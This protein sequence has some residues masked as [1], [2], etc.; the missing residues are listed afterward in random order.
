MKVYEIS[1][2]IPLPW[3]NFFE[4]RSFETLQ[5]EFF[6]R[7]HSEYLHHGMVEEISSFRALKY[8]R[9]KDFSWIHPKTFPKPFLWTFIPFKGRNFRGINFRGV[10][11][12]PRKF[13]PAKIFYLL[14][15]QKLIPAKKILDIFLKNTQIERFY[16]RKL[17]PANYH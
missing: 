1:F 13:V 17:I 12:K 14:N 11:R 9:M 15:L 3:L 5:N 4:F 16:S 8:F 10:F 6:T 7:C 2:C